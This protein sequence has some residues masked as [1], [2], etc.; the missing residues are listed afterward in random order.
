MSFALFTLPKYQQTTTT[1]LPPESDHLMSTIWSS[2][3]FITQEWLRTLYKFLREVQTITI[4]FYDCDGDIILVS[5]T[6]AKIPQKLNYESEKIQ[7]LGENGINSKLK[8]RKAHSS[9]L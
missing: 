7:I 6:S 1:P 9:I 2:R 5:D 8:H 3:Q 4:C